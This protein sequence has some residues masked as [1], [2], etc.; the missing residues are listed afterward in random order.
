M[1]E[2]TAVIYLGI[3]ENMF[4]TIPIQGYFSSSKLKIFELPA[5]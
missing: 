4:K 2:E 1:A 5:T 3:T